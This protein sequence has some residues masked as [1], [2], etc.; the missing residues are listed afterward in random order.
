MDFT[1]YEKD[2]LERHIRIPKLQELYGKKPESLRRFQN[3]KDIWK[4]NGRK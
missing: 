4:D 3:G 1:I 2:I